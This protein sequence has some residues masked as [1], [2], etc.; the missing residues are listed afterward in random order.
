MTEPKKRMFDITKIPT[1]HPSLINTEPDQILEIRDKMR[2][3]QEL[4]LDEMVIWNA[5]KLNSW[6]YCTKHK[7]KYKFH[8]GC[9]SCNNVCKFCDKVVEVKDHARHHET[10][11]KMPKPMRKKLAKT[12]QT[13]INLGKLLDDLKQRKETPE[14]KARIASIRLQLT[15]L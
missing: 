5:A 14:I 7:K 15:R 13:R 2:D 1:V 11:S 9:P 6:A 12:M 8:D 3:K 4:T 10:C